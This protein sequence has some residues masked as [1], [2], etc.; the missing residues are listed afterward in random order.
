MNSLYDCDGCEPDGQVFV[1]VIDAVQNDG[2]SS[3][4]ARHPD[5]VQPRLP[6]SPVQVQ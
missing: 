3:L 6:V 5:P 2:T 1:K 4:L